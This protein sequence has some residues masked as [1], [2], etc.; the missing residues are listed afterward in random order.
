MEI[1]KNRGITRVFD[2]SKIPGEIQDLCVVN[3]KVLKAHPDFARALVGAWYEV[4]G[5]MTKK[6]A[7]GEAAI[8]KM[9]EL[10]KAS[11]VEFTGQLKT[12][13]MFYTPQTAS[14]YI[15]SAE[16]KQK[17]D[18][19]RKFCFAHNLL[20]ENAKSVDVV[21]IE[22]PDGTIQGDKNKVKM[23][24]VSTYMDEAAAGKIAL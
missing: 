9:A 11:A 12:T 22:Y 2:S 4:M 10:S 6:D 21:G 7:S 1:E 19:V 14:T 5:V 16:L 3:T 15:K 8:K 18:L 13:A 20:G 24:Y 23:H 17:Q